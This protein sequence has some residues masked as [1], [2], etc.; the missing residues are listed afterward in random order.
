MEARRSRLKGSAAVE[1]RRKVSL[2]CIFSNEVN[3]LGIIAPQVTLETLFT[4]SVTT[5]WMKLQV[6]TLGGD[7]LELVLLI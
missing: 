2:E 3:H 5:S 7:Q 1:S 4:T 6:L